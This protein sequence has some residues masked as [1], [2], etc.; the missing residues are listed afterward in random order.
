MSRQAQCSLC[1]R[2]FYNHN[3]MMIVLPD[4]YDDS[5]CGRCNEDIDKSINQERNF[6]NLESVSKKEI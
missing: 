4:T 6:D 3:G 1:G 5:K 2:W